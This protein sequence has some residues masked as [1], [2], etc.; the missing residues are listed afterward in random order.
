MKDYRGV[1]V[2]ENK[3]TGEKYIGISVKMRKRWKNHRYRLNNNI[4]H[5][6]KLQNA[7]NKYGAE[8]FKFYT[9]Y[10]AFTKNSKELL[11]LERFYIEKYDTYTNGYNCTPGGENMNNLISRYRPY[12][13]IGETNS[14]AKLTEN[15]VIDI[16]IRRFEG[17]AIKSIHQRYSKVARETISEI[18]NNRKWTYLPRDLETL[19]N[20]ATS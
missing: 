13:G 19:K 18:C 4:H 6:P 15:E 10:F 16:L 20:M 2:I 5:S 11:E 14:R 8:N 3:I 9:I 17:E 7:W 1:Y 12:T